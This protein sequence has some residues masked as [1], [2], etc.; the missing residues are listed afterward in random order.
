M[1]LFEIESTLPKLFVGV[2]P[3]KNG[4][5]TAMDMAGNSKRWIMPLL[6][7]KIDAKGLYDLMMTL[8]EKYSPVVI[9]EDVHSI[10]GTSASSNFTF[11]FVCGV[12]EAVVIAHSFKLIK[13]AP[14]T[15]QKEIWINSDLQY[16]PPKD[17]KKPTVN[18]KLTSLI[19]AK[20]LFPNVDFRKS[21]SKRVTKD[22]DGIIDSTL[23]CEWGRRK[24]L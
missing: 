5:L 3:G 6:G 23:I 1:S 4:A 17:G 12:I 22:H 24:N 15:W 8:K 2:D 20:R 11:G 21:D 18:T 9:I 14:K 7:D 16:N 10:F 13:V 19:C